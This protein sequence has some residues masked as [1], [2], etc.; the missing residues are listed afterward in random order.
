MGWVG[1]WLGLIPR[2]AVVDPAVFPETDYPIWC[3]ECGYRLDGLADGKCPECGSEFSLGNL[4]VE[5]YARGRRARF[6][7][8]RKWA[9]RLLRLSV[10]AWIVL[11]MMVALLVWQP[12]W[13]EDALSN[14]NLGWLMLGALGLIALNTFAST[15]VVGYL[16]WKMAPP[17]GKA[18]AVRRA[19][20]LQAGR[21]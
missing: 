1:R 19:L 12:R 16:E 10:A 13:F 18:K 14:G 9:N 3:L 8:R 17:R 7:R 5:I 11:G 2:G 6:D 15:M 4:L 21:T 20:R